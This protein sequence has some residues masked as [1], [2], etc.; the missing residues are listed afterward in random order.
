VL[1]WSTVASVYVF[2]EQR[3]VLHNEITAL[4]MSSNLVNLEVYVCE[5]YKMIL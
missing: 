3:D 1:L 4:E 2:R 5:Q